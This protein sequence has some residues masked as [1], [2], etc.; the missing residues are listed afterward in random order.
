MLKKNKENWIKKILI[1][2]NPEIKD[3]LKKKI[4]F[5]DNGYLDSLMIIR[6][7]YEVEKKN[8]KKINPSK[9]KRE[10][11]SSIEAISKLLR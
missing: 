5:V 10:Q 8:K 3:Q 9:L 7:L 11:F 1:K 4:N 2:I 6:L